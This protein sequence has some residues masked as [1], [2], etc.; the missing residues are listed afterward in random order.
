MLIVPPVTLSESPLASLEF[1]S[2]VPDVLVDGD[3][4]EVPTPKVVFPTAP[5]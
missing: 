1:E 3:D 2:T 5:E 4:G